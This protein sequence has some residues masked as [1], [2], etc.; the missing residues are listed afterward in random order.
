MK[1]HELVSALQ[2]LDRELEV[3]CYTES[4]DLVPPRHLF[5]LLHIEGA[6]T[7]IGERRRGEDQVATLALRGG[8][9]SETIAILQITSDF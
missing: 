9:N 1:V 4:E 3:M 6:D 7:I 2:K 8:P 5:R